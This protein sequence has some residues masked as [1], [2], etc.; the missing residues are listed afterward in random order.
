MCLRVEE[1]CQWTTRTWG[2]AETDP[3]SCLRRSHPCWGILILDFSL[4]NW[5]TLVLATKFVVPFFFF[6]AALQ[7]QTA[8][9]N[10]GDL[11]KSHFLEEKM[12]R[13]GLESQGVDMN[14][15]PL[16]MLPLGGTPG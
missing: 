10:S 9:P 14:G 11:K 12:G 3:L 5:G 4:Q 2:G 16:R 8:E 15:R 6:L 1:R 13:R 7:T